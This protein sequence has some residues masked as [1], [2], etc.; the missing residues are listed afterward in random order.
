MQGGCRVCS[1]QEE[2]CHPGDKTL[3]LLQ[4]VSSLNITLGEGLGGMKN[5]ITMQH[6]QQM[7]RSDVTKLRMGV[8]EK[9]KQS[10]HQR[11]EHK[12]HK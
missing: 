4:F 7:M 3:G 10:T 5:V 1:S 6:M 9:K 2:Q 11:L 12:R 8:T